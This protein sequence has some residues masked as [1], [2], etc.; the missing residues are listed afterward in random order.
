MLQRKNL[1]A[2]I[3]RYKV[4]FIGKDSSTIQAVCNFLHTLNCEC[5]IATSSEALAKLEGENFDAVLV[6]ATHSQSPQQTILAIKETRPALAERILL[7]TGPEPAESD[8]FCGLP[9]ISIEKPLSQLWTRLEKVLAVPQPSRFAP[10]GMQNARLIFDSF[11]A[12]PAVSGTRGSLAAARQLTYQHDS[13][14]VNLLIR[15]ESKADRI[16]LVGQVLDV[17][18]RA[19]HGLPVLLSNGSRT[20]GET[21]TS[22]FGEF[23]LEVGLM[24]YAGLQ[25]RL[26]EGSWIHMPLE[27]LD[28]KR[29]PM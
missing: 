14:T 17:S 19:V 24:E 29:K 7:I 8:E 9:Y 26:A 23:G 2:P 5:T 4:L 6:D 16:S 1:A 22:Q 27:N 10:P 20:L 28:W 3:E 25:I 13:A 18:M 21:T 11:S 15:L 12:P